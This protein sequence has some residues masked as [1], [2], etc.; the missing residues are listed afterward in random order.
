MYFVD[1]RKIEEHLEFLDKGIKL[2]KDSSFE[3]SL[4]KLALE[5]LHHLFIESMIDV[6]NNIIDGFI[7]RD[8]GSYEDIIEI[9]ADERVIPENCSINLKG[10]VMMRKPLMQKYI[11]M[12][13]AALEE[14]IKK[15]IE[16][17]ENFSVHVR[18]Y[19]NEELGAVSAFLPKDDK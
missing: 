12:D 19:L 5:R 18:K 2:F 3:T 8:P 15:H 11:T 6:G 16:S 17:L 1:R 14:N 10:I 7:M 9:L 4:E 13:H